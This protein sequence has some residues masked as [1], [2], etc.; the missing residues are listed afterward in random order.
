MKQN[1]TIA[2]H[3]RQYI[4][5]GD[6][7]S[8]PGGKFTGEDF[9]HLE[10]ILSGKL[11][12]FVVFNNAG[13]KPFEVWSYDTMKKNSSKKNTLKGFINFC[14]TQKGYVYMQKINGKETILK[15]LPSIKPVN[16]PFQNLVNVLG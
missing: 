10:K 7:L 6:V 3:L 16:D 15:K 9:L 12:N 11:D 2:D 5:N 13:G 14:N 8:G 4:N 1:M